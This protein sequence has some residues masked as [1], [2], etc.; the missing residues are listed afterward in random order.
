MY[1]LSLSLYIYI[2]IYTHINAAN[3]K[4]MQ[5]LV[6]ATLKGRSSASSERRLSQESCNNIYIYIYIYT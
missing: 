3:Q 5:Q 1:V 6:G 4:E 2:Y